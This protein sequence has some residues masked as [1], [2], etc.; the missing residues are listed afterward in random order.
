MAGETARDIEI[1]EPGAMAGPAHVRLLDRQATGWDA[2]VRSRPEA[3]GW[4]TGTWLEVIEDVFGHDCQRW[5]AYDEHGRMCG[6]LPV[7][8]LRSR[9]FGDFGVSLPFVN[10]GG[11]LVESEE[12]RTAL[13][14][15]AGA[16]AG[17]L[18]MRHIEFRDLVP[19]SD[20]WPE[21]GD[22]VIM[23]RPLPESADALWGELNTKMRTRVRRPQKREGITVDGGRFEALDDFYQV[24][25]RNMRDL[26][27]PVYGRELFCAIL[28]RFPDTYIVV[29]RNE[30]MPVAA[31]FLF[32]H[33]D[34]LEVPWASALREY[35]PWGVNMLLYWHCLKHAVEQGYGEFDF[36]RSS[37]DSGTYR[38]K[39]HWGATPTQCRW[40]YWLAPGAD[41]P[42]LTPDNPRFQLAISAW[43]RLPVA[44]ANRL[45]PPIVKNLP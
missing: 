40:H 10:A 15:A 5:A 26:G 1:N 37:V 11:A 12:T 18:G 4:H 31:A 27:T 41:M 45:G 34:R 36:G 3:S 32:G 23:S 24:F 16:H 44:V 25:A 33:P 43:Q 38:F 7:V 13:M 28:E 30:G 8:R 42:G 20:A 19:L 9:L 2:F 22:K 6:V 17:E 29:V 35:N 39:E 21:R 14:E